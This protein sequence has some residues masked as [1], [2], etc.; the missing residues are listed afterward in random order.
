MVSVDRLLSDG[1]PPVFRI[2]RPLAR[3]PF[4]LT[5]D[6]GG[7]RIPQRLG[8][9]GLDDEALRAHVAW[10]IGI[11]EL[12]DRLSERL[13]AFLIVQNYSRLV[14]DMNRPLDS[15]D[16]IVKL[17]ERTR[18]AANEGLSAL[19][20]R[21]RVDEIFE[22]YH[23]RIRAELD[24][25]REAGRPAL[26]VALHS[27]TPVYLDQPRQWHA[28]VLYGRDARLA[29]R[30]LVALRSDDSLVVGDNQPYAVSDATDFSV[31]THGEQRGLA[32]VEIEIRQDLLVREADLDGWARRLGDI[33]EEAATQVLDA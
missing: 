26:L 21:Q 2:G 19:E 20:T 12:G 7:R 33:L 5:C 11:A 32:H 14:I 24:A 29:H 4:V 10:D 1:D 17:S 15:P 25:R 22:P 28:G 16:S 8:N 23:G 30:M 6:H 13:D 27:F 3:S 9:L 18:V 31:V